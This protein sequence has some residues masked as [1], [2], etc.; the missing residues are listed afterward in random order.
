MLTTSVRPL[1]CSGAVMTPF[2]TTPSSPRLLWPLAHTV[3]SSFR[4]RVWA[5]PPATARTP[6]KEVSRMGTGASV[7]EPVPSWP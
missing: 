1:T 4:N 5:L 7:V 3:L 2:W 6:L